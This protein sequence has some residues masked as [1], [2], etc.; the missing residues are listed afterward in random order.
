MASALKKSSR[1]KEKLYKRWLL[2]NRKE[3]EEKFKEYRK[4]FKKISIECEITYYKEST[5]II[6]LNNCGRI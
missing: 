1:N 4:Q 3:D 5:R 6:Q 2:T